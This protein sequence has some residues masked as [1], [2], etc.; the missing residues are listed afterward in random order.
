[1]AKYTAV[2]VWRADPKCVNPG[3]V[4]SEIRQTPK[5]TH[6]VSA[7]AEIPR[8]GRVERQSSLV[9]RAAEGFRR[10]GGHGPPLAVV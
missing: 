10:G 5:S 9:V 2:T 8:T 1:M 3:N 4:V 6:C 7:F